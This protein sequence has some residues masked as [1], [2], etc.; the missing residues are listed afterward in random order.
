M[1][2]TCIGRKNFAPFSTGA[3]KGPFPAPDRRL[4][5]HLVKFLQVSTFAAVKA[6]RY[7][8]LVALLGLVVPFGV[9]AQNHV[10]RAME[11][12]R[13]RQQ[14]MAQAQVVSEGGKAQQAGNMRMLVVDGDTTYLDKLPAVY[15]FSRGKHTSEK[16]W[17][18]Y[19]KLVWRFARV[20]PYAIASGS[21]VRQVDSTLNAENYGFI[22]KERYISAIQKQLFKDFEGSFRDMSI[23]QGTVLL[24]LIDRETGITP[25]DLIK[26]YKSG[27]A[28]G[29]WQGVAK[30]FDNDLK[31]Q[32]DPTGADRQLEELCQI[33]HAGEFRD[34]YWSVF[35]EEPPKV[36]VPDR[37]IP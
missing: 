32:F 2:V 31:S 15:I 14:A 7:M 36:E 23:Q 5:R 30:L 26:N 35:W 20:Y 21:L 10:R 24:K 11:K 8:V 29:F 9:S 34:L 19:Y 12:A 28:A 27:V 37:Y 33:W 13:Q 4:R 25:Y 1:E 6:F 18:E 16:S 3:F 17:R 22:R